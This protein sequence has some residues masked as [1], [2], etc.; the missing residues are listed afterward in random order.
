M[1]CWIPDDLQLAGLKTAVNL[2]LCMYKYK[3]GSLEKL[4]SVKWFALKYQYIFSKHT[5][6]AVLYRRNS[7]CFVSALAYAQQDSKVPMLCWHK[8]YLQGFQRRITADL[9]QIWLRIT[10]MVIFCAIY[11]MPRF[12]ASRF[13]NSFLVVEIRADTIFA[14]P[15]PRDAVTWRFCSCAISHWNHKRRAFGIIYIKLVTI[16]RSNFQVV[17]TCAGNAR[18]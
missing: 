8:V 9:Q 18:Y 16:I 10:N 11:S 15:K 12:Q 2:A 14:L 13:E 6:T 3:Y 4:L 17:F 7:T 1:K 5:R